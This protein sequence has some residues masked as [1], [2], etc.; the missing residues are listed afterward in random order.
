MA[1]V[2]IWLI[3][4]LDFD[5]HVNETIAIARAIQIFPCALGLLRQGWATDV[6]PL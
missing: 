5:R 4:Q 6:F 2:A 1:C 3:N